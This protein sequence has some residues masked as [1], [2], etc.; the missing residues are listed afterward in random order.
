[1]RKVFSSHRLENTEGVAELLGKA[2]I[3]VRILNGRSYKGN[4]RR[5]FS[6]ADPSP[7]TSDVWVV[8]SEDQRKAREILREAGLIDTTRPTGGYSTPTFRSEVELAQARSPARKRL[9]RVKLGVLA[10]ITAVVV[11][12]GMH[13]LNQ[14]PAIAPEAAPVVEA[15]IASPP[16]DGSITATLAPVARVVF[17]RTLEDVDTP[18]ACLGVDRGDAPAAMITALA[19]AHP[20]L[21]LVPATAC[22]E[23]ADEDQ[24]SFERA[25]GRPAT[26]VDVHVFRPSGPEHGTVEVTSYH[27]R[28]WA[29]YETLE[30]ARVDG[31]WQVTDVIKRVES[32]GLMGF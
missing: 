27:H 15:R 18:V 17:T 26:M 19:A 10:L 7:S 6:Y 16:F 11:A 29:A 20:G 23:V 24:G 3:E 9:F 2:G 12:A 4:R 1:M 21:S 25:T 8:R 31:A 30:V 28:G 32:R 13:T 5:T 14:P 22:Q